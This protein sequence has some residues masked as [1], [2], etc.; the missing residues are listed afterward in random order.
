MSAFSYHSYHRDARKYNLSFSHPQNDSSSRMY[1]NPS[2]LAKIKTQNVQAGTQIERAGAGGNIGRR[3][4]EEASLEVA[5]HGILIARP[6]LKVAIK[7]VRD[8]EDALDVL[9]GQGLFVVDG[10]GLCSAD[11]VLDLAA[12]QIVL[13]QT[14]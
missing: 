10:E 9:H 1:P 2:P 14:D 7:C 3:R 13:A 11:R 4:K 6:T 5:T 12:I 8:V